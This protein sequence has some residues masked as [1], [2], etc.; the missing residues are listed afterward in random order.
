MADIRNGRWTAH[1]DAPFVVFLIG[2]RFNK[3]WKIHKWGPVIQ[4]HAAHDRRT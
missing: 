4:G 2:M 3:L 1:S